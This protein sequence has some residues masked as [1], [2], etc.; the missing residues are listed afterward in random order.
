MSGPEGVLLGGCLCGDVRYRAARPASPG[1]LC[2]CVSCRQ[3]SGAPA[4]AWFTIRREDLIFDKGAVTEFNSSEQVVRGF[5]GRCG[6]AL[7]YTHGRYPEYVDVTTASL[8]HPEAVPPAD[9][10]WTSHRISW[11]EAADTLPEYPRSR[12]P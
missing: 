4:V 1:T 12:H 8:D 5:C 9:H 11:M 3:A 2:H 6:T 7:T 10:T